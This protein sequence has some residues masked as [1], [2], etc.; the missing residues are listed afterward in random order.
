VH[1]ET[2]DVL[3]P[4]GSLLDEDAVDAIDNHGID[5]VKVRT[6]AFLRHALGRLRQVL[7]AATSAAARW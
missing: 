5:E 6:A 3:Y 7:R 2:Q 1:P 4:S